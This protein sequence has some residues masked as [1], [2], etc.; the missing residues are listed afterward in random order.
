MVAWEL[1]EKKK[2]KH[3]SFI[4]MNTTTALGI[5]ITEKVYDTQMDISYMTRKWYLH[6]KQL[7]FGLNLT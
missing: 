4:T 2:K 6:S 3:R 1:K 7:T 5:Q